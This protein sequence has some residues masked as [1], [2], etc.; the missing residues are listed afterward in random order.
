MS[1]EATTHRGRTGNAVLLTSLALAGCMLPPHRDLTFRTADHGA[2][3]PADGAGLGG[4]ADASGG[5]ARPADQGVDPHG[6]GAPADARS[7]TPDLRAPPAADLS[8]P[9]ADQREPSAD[10]TP[11]GSD[12]PTAFPDARRDDP[13]SR[14][15]H[16]DAAVPTDAIPP[17]ADAAPDCHPAP[18]TCNGVDDDCDGQTDEGRLCAEGSI[19]RAGGCVAV[20]LPPDLVRIAPGDFTMGSPVGEL[21]RGDD[22]APHAVTIAH[23][24]ALKVTEVTQ[25]EWFAV[26]QTAPS[27]FP[28]CG[29]DCALDNVS[30]DD[31]VA[32]C[33]A[34]SVL[35]GLPQC[36]AEG[37]VF[38]GLDCLGY[39]L[40]TEAEWEY[41]TRA[42]THT[43]FF[44]GAITAVDCA[45]DPVLGPVAW[46][47]ANAGNT[48]HAVRGKVQNAFGLFDVHGNV[49]EWVN[50][51][52]DRHYG[53]NDQPATDPLG[54]DLGGE[55][56]VRGGGW[57][58]G[59]AD[60]RAARRDHAGP[61]NHLNYIGFRPARS[62]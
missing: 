13:D 6:D 17:I 35:E 54:S 14:V 26:M 46:Y 53:N 39:R 34:R 59:G 3:P 51:R 48:P 22:E 31:A 61:A 5:T 20:A 56:V 19:C 29:D 38:A 36:Y 2:T 62:L 43:A 28:D 32:Y 4:T 49:S 37:R 9:G 55:R 45:A 27:G 10:A 21:G 15:V 33:N 11:P 23:A 57:L 47:C 16:G 30:W 1:T 52:Y 44:A 18:E 50:D 40:P 41:A 58:L 60:A 12:G 8:V 42:G 24:F 7:V 25:A